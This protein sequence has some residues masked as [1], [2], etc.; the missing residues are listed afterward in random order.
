MSYN[1]LM[2]DPETY[3]EKLDESANSVNYQLYSGKYENSRR[4]RIELGQVGGYG[5]SQYTGNVVDLE[6]DL[7][8]RTRK[9]SKCASRKYHPKRGSNGSRRN[10]SAP[11]SCQI[12][13][14]NNRITTPSSHHT[15][16]SPFQSR[17]YPQKKKFSLW[18]LLGF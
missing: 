11:R 7:S 16:A 9:A 2:Y 8:G 14:Y 5:V 10:L 12:V 4:C 3:K 6:S 13:D 15:K 17:N 1:R 18:S